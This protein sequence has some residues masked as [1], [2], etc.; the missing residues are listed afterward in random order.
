MRSIA[1]I[2]PSSCII[3]R[4]RQQLYQPLIL[5]NLIFHLKIGYN[6]P[7]RI[8]LFLHR[9]WTALHI[10]YPMS[11][12]LWR[13]LQEPDGTLHKI[14]DIEGG[15]HEAGLKVCFEFL[16]FYGFMIHIDSAI[17]CTV[18]WELCWDYRGVSQRPEIS[19]IFVVVILSIELKD[20]LWDAI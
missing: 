15:E 6:F 16:L 14:I 2:F 17:G 5:I 8:S 13:G 1:P 12:L 11:Q 18:L 3:Q 7:N 19:S 4:L 10:I 20:I 9:K